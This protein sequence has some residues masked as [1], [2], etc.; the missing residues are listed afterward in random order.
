M[1]IF[2]ITWPN[3]NEITKIECESAKSAHNFAE[4]NVTGLGLPS[5][6]YRVE[7]IETS[8]SEITKACFVEGY[9]AAFG[10]GYRSNNPHY[11]ATNAAD[12]DKGFTRAFARI[13]AGLPSEYPSE[14]DFHK[15][16][17]KR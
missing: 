5:D 9:Q 2:R 17:G 14:Y 16:A 11:G 13:N 6:G 4:N 3:G 10:G 12:W 1:A 15:I 7:A 8:E